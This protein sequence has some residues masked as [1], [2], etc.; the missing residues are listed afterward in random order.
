MKAPVDVKFVQKK[1]FD[2]KRGSK[3]LLYFSLCQLYLN[4]VIL[5][6][7]YSFSQL[8]KVCDPAIKSQK[9]KAVDRKL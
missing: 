3:N 2:A 9:D 5:N 8:Q 6:L 7:F 4:Q 1:L